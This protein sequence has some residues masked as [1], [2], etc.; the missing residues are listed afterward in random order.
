M[1]Q[2]NTEQKNVAHHS[3]ETNNSGGG[4]FCL[5]LANK[6]S[7]NIITCICSSEFALTS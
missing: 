2:R 4:H 3:A 7:I 1:K 5:N 6:L